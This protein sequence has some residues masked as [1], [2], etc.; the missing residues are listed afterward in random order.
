MGWH[1]TPPH[2]AATHRTPPHRTLICPSL[3]LPAP[4]HTT[5]TLHPTHH[6]PY[7]HTQH[8]VGLLQRQLASAESSAHTSDMRVAA[9]EERLAEVSRELDGARRQ[10]EFMRT[11]AEAHQREANAVGGCGIGTTAT[12]NN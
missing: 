7:A 11:T 4:P 8:E 2:P 5:L 12:C 1:P 9:L 3:T 6:P 10:T